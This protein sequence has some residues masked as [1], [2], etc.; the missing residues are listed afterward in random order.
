MESDSALKRKE[1]WFMDYS[2]DDSSGH[3]AKW[4]KPVRKSQILCNSTHMRYLIRVTKNHKEGRMVAAKS[5]VGERN[6]E[7]L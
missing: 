3:Y 6:G 7:V 1:I 5:W 4:D 2:V